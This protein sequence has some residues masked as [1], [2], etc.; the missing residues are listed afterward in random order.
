M[1]GSIETVSDW[2]ELLIIDAEKV[3]LFEYHI[4]G[5]SPR[6][7]YEIEVTAQNGMGS[8]VANE[9]FIF[10]TPGSKCYDVMTSLTYSSNN[11]TVLLL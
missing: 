5:L 3:P 4:S 7:S 9:Q 1:N 8:S 10:T 11:I 6:T 2:K